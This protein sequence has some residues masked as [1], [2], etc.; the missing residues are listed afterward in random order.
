MVH[1]TVRQ[2]KKCTLLMMMPFFTQRREIAWRFGID[3]WQVDSI[4]YS[5]YRNICAQIETSFL[6]IFFRDIITNQSR[7]EREKS[8]GFHFCD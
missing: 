7:K 8:A 5:K 1:S 4:D 3:F 6:W 2:P